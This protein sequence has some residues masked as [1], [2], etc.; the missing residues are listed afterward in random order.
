[1]FEPAVTRAKLPPLRL[2]DLRHT[3]AAIAID[4]GAQP[5]HVQRMLG[6]ASIQMTLGTYGHLFA[7]REEVL[8]AKL[9]VRAR[10]AAASF[11]ASLPLGASGKVV[12]WPP[13]G[14]ELPPDLR[15]LS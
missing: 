6:H 3:A 10:K 12:P 14:Q 4:T 5:I 13:Q 2:H 15:F 8:A 11:A 1:V 7:K 9:D